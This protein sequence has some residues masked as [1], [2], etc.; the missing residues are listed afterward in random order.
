LA[1]HT[2]LLWRVPSWLPHVHS[3]W[4]LLLLVLVH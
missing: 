4:L 3:S 2:L 1:R